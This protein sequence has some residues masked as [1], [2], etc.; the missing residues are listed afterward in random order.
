MINKLSLDKTLKYVL[1][2]IEGKRYLAC[3][4]RWMIFWNSYFYD[5]T[6]ILVLDLS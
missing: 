3:V 1:K 4:K 5:S 2:L 6:W